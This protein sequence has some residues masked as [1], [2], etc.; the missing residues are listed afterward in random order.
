MLLPVASSNIITSLWKAED[1]STAYISEKFY[2]YTAKGFTYSQA[3]QKAKIDLLHDASMTQFHAPQYW[4]HLI[5]IGDVQD[6][7]SFSYWWIVAIVIVVIGM[8]AFTLK[9]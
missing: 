4:S 7:K 8:L 3:L 6:E 9:I 2:Y 1:K 5:F